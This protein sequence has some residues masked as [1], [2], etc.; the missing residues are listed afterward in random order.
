MNFDPILPRE[1]IDAMRAAQ[2][3]PDRLITDYLDDAAAARP[4]HVAV[5][6]FNSM[7]G[8]ATSVSYRQ[9]QRISNRIA[10]GLVA[11]GVE[12]GDVVSFQLPNWWHAAALY[13]ACTRI[14]AAINPLMPIFRHRELKFML[15]FAESK[16]LLV[17]RSFRGFDHPAMIAELRGE[18]PALEHVLVVDGRE[19]DA[20]EAVLLNQRWEDKLD[21]EAIFRERR[22]T[23]NDISQL[24]YTSGTTGQPKGVMHTANTIIGNIERIIEQ[25]GL[26]GDDVIFMASPLA[27]NTGFYYG[28]TMPIMLHTKSVLQDI[29]NPAVAAQRIQDEGATFTMAASAFLS[30]LTFSAE[31]ERYDMRSLRIFLTAGA[32]IP[33][34]LVQTAMEKFGMRVVSGWG[35]S[36][37]GLVTTTLSGDAPEKVFETDGAPFPGMELRVVDE[38]GT[39]LPP[40]AEGRLQTRGCANFVGYLKRP[41]AYDLD[42]DGWFETGDNAR[43]DADGYI[44]IAGRSKDILIRGGENVPVVEVEEL[45]YRHPAVQDAAI[46]AMPDERL[47]ERGCA[48]VVL[49]EGHELTF[50]E[51]VQYLEGC[52]LAKDYF[53]ERLEVVAEMPRTPSGKIQKF[54]LRDVAQH[55]TPHSIA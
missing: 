36:E 40:G 20:F 13:L 8:R 29:W 54:K 26:T 46:V 44:R 55:L 30:D 27:H 17:P 3:W 19:D 37:N 16:L 38:G 11:L 18:L 41:E 9:L 15:R 48:F 31:V 52:K 14:G 7:T 35:M 34:V 45:L 49:R 4:D 42:P 25:V 12:A 43:M 24:V 39:P 28:M 51:M 6:D 50:P 53:P 21:A 5:T 2:L 47:G 22:P 32:P 23:P 10:L 1:R 33:R